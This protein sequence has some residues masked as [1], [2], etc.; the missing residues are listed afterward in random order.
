MR[1]Y[2]IT[3]NV[4]LL[5]ILS[6][7]LLNCKTINVVP[8]KT[9]LPEKTVI[10]TFDDGPNVHENTTARLLDILEKY[11]YRAMFALLGENAEKYPELVKRIHDEGHYIVN[12]GYYDKWAVRLDND[13]FLDNL[14]KGE[15]AITSALGEMPVLLYRPQGG[16][17]H[18]RHRTI[19]EQKGYTLVPATIRVYDAVLEGSSRDKI[20]NKVLKKVDSQKGGII[21]LHDSRDSWYR[22]ETE[23]ARDPE[24]AFNRSW[25]P[26][27]VEELIVK[28]LEKG[29][30]IGNPG[31]LY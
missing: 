28:L 24:G 29:Y 9:G 16:F 23:L 1:Y 27:L 22:A 7:L 21:L 6:V 25:I 5:L 26:D 17:Y 15:K 13:E 11:R 18:E 10:L 14:L 8:Q 12:H 3:V 31:V 4:L 30:V 20:L 19:W 2:N